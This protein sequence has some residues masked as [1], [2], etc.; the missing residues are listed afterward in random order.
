MNVKR[1]GRLTALALAL[2]AILATGSYFG[3]WDIHLFGDYY[4][5]H[6][7][8]TALCK[9]VP[10]LPNEKGN[11]YDIIV[12]DVAK[13]G[14]NNSN[15]IYGIAKQG[16]FIVYPNANFYPDEATWLAALKKIGIT[17]PELKVPVPEPRGYPLILPLWVWLVAAAIFILVLLVV[18]NYLR[19][20]NQ[21]FENRGT[22]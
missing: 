6:S 2:S 11:S 4:I 18:W 3:D 15:A 20:R 1:Y 14:H 8:G 10:R 21:S 5:I 12:S 16:Y 13:Y 19:K 7:A 17:S 22:I 9:K